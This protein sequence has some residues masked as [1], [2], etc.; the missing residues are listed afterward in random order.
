CIPAGWLWGSHGFL[1][2][3]GAID[4]AGSAGV[5]L[6]GG[7]AALVCAWMVGPRIGRYDEGRSSL[8]LGN[9]T[10]AILGMFMLWWGWFGFNCGSTYGMSGNLWKYSARTAVT[11]LQASIAAGLVGMIYSWLG[12]HRLEVSDC[13]NSVLGG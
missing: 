6:N 1:Y 12:N 9:P 5:H 4:I 2:K 11:T 3:M 13:V 7:A 10:N 8:P